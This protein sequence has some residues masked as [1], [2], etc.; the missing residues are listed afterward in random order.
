MK[1]NTTDFESI[2]DDLYIAKTDRFFSESIIPRL[3]TSAIH[4]SNKTQADMAAELNLNSNLM[5]M[6]KQGRTKVPL[7]R[8][9]DIAIALELPVEE[10]VLLVLNEYHSELL[11]VMDKTFIVPRNKEEA[12][13]IK[14]MKVQYRR[15]SEPRENSE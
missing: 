8:A 10:F 14:E 3:I 12:K 15:D 11:D 5:T 13:A 6:F 1:P 2:T 4:K 9:R 7:T